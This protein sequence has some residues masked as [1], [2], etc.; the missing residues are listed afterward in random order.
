MKDK[1]VHELLTVLNINHMHFY[2]LY[3]VC[4]L[5]VSHFYQFLSFIGLHRQNNQQDLNITSRN[6]L[7][8]IKASIIHWMVL[9]VAHQNLSMVMLGKK[10]RIAT[11]SWKHL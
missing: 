11:N 10:P 1:V 3:M 5:N 7:V 9:V 6:I 4:Q 2:Q 8:V